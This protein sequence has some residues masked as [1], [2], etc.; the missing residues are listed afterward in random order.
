MRKYNYF[1]EVKR[2]RAMTSVADWDDD[3]S[4]PIPSYLWDDVHNVAEALDEI[5]GHAFIAPCGDGSVHLNY[6]LPGRLLVLEISGVCR[7]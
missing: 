5:Y 2:L 7:D 1:D 4:P 6:A 3:G